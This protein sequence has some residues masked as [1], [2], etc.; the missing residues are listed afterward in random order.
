M[1]SSKKASRSRHR[2]ICF[3]PILARL[4]S[5]YYLRLDTARG[6][7]QLREGPSDEELL[8]AVA[9]AEEFTGVVV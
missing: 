1:P 9:S 7:K 4:A 3:R 6:F 5:K 2:I 8:D